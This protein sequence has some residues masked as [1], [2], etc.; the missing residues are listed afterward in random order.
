MI[1]S[2]GYRVKSKKGIIFGRWANKVLKEHLIKG[3][4]VN[5]RRLE[6][7]EKKVKLIDIAKR[8]NDEV[9]NN[10]LKEVLEVINNFQEGLDILDNYD[11]RSFNKVK[12]S[13]SDKQ[14]TY[15][16]SLS[17]N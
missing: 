14:I 1:I 5:E 8:I 17:Y 12:G 13:S 2:V 11:H 9:N 15:N 6:Y 10:D 7:L 3:Y 4:T 16:N